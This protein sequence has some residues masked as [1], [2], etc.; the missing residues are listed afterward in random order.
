[1]KTNNKIPL[2]PFLFVVTVYLVAMF[3]EQ[4][5]LLL[6]FKPLIVATLLF[7][8]LNVTGN[9][10]VE[11]KW[12]MIFAL[13][14]CMMGDTFLIFSRGDE[15]FFILGLSAFLVGHIFYIFVYKRIVKNK[16]ISFHLPKTLF[17]TAYVAFLLY[18]L[19][20]RAD[21]LWLPVV[22]YALVIGMMLAFAFHLTKIG[23][24]GWLIAAGGFL[25]VISDSF[26]ALNKF[27]TPIPQNHWIVMITYIAAQ[28]LI[29][30]GVTRYILQ[31]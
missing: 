5:W 6:I 19:I 4:Q 3:F 12:W 31:R 20:P 28:F 13:V 9:M 29:V 2:I 26:I 22:L 7:Y 18:L 25:F 30:E 15:F 8:F 21:V 14:F 23:K 10:F 16:F 11:F 1:M 24:M 17:V 27:Y